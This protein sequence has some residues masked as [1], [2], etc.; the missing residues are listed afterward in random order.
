[1]TGI[2]AISDDPET[3]QVLISTALMN[4]DGEGL[5]E[6]REYFR[7]KM[8]KIGAAKPTEEESAELQ[9]E[10]ANQAPDPNAQYLAA[11]AQQAE[12]EAAQARAKTVLTVSQASETE[13]KTDK[14]KAE[15]MKTIADIDHNGMR[16]E[17]DA[18]KDFKGLD[19]TPAT[20]QRDNMRE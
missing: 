13:A 15:T 11:A 9:A 12:A 20:A 2:A 6:T 7:R 14:L 16:L 1:L 3:R 19:E 17:M 10:M 8:I 5:S 18:L 4:M